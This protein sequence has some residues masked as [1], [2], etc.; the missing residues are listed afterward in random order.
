MD[1]CVTEVRQVLDHAL[2]SGKQVIRILEIGDGILK[3]LYIMIYNAD[4][5][6]IASASLCT[7]LN[8]LFS[9]YPS[10]RVDYT[11]SGH[12]QITSPGVR[13]VAFD[14]DTVLQQ[15]NLPAFTYDIVIEVHSL[16]FAADLQGLLKSLN[17][18]LVP[19]G[20]LLALEANGTHQSTGGKWIDYVFSPQGSWPG[21]RSGKQ[22][23]RF[24]QSAWDKQLRRAG[25]KSLNAEKDRETA[26]FLTLRAQ[27]FS[28]PVLS[29]SST[30]V[31]Q[32]VIFSFKLA[33]VLD[34]QKTLLATTSFRW[35]SFRR[36][37]RNHHG[38]FR[39]WCCHWLHSR[40]LRREL[41]SVD[42]NLVLFDPVWKAESKVAIIQQLSNFPYLES[43]IVVDSSG[44]VLVPRLFSFPPRAPAILD[45]SRY[46]VMEQSGNVI[47]PALPMLGPR[48]VM[49]KIS[50]VSNA[51][52][53]LQGVVGM[54]SRAASSK[55]TVGTRVVTIAQSVLSNFVVVQEDQVAELPED[56]ND[57]ASANLALPL[58]FMALA[59]R[60]DL[61]PLESL[62]EIQVIILQTG[63][64]ANEIVRM[65][66]HIGLAPLLV[67]PSLP[68]TLPRLSPGDIIMY[69]LPD[70][71]ARAI[72]S[73][74]GVLLFNWQ[75]ATH[76]A[77]CAVAQNPWFVCT[78][79]KAHMS[80]FL[81]KV[82]VN[83][84]SLTPEQ[85]LPS[86][87]EVSSS[88][89][90]KRDKSYLIVGGIGSLGLQIAI[91]MYRVSSTSLGS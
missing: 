71:S 72:P 24:S 2:K 25:F 69:G 27:K 79:F 23:R 30:D 55:W 65:L 40:S 75:D 8:T 1:A 35:T 12:E 77:L 36:L 26:L 81:R 42:I 45:P 51:E 56:C 34:L 61:R 48:Q 32:L 33:H 29:A 50:S 44:I 62:R 86:D 90:F 39:W 13:T 6:C 91:W 47:Q 20:F 52:S 28:L 80:S 15:Y 87:F 60:L 9:K 17:E 21:L 54:I 31:K 49:I 66:Q 41:V 59:L 10:L 5:R 58:L 74:T 53:G 70:V 43:E 63:E 38:K 22:Y 14:I 84:G 19:G 76:G 64:I 82:T 67:S 16:G 57:G 46:W 88:I 89:T 4:V 37:D 83:I 7:L 78:T 18:L 85:Q 68:L 73:V 11:A 3:H